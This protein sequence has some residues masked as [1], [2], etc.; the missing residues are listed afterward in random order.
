[1][2]LP[3]PKAKQ[4][5]AHSDEPRLEATRFWY[6]SAGLYSQFE[7]DDNAQP[8]IYLIVHETEPRNS[9]DG[10]PIWNI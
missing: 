8:S 4:T 2:Y 1:M 5:G 3:S 9:G 10:P 6:L 7:L